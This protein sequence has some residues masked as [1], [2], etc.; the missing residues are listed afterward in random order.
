MVQG[1]PSLPRCLS[2]V[3]DDA[4]SVSGQ[5]Q[6]VRWVSPGCAGALPHGQRASRGWFE[7]CQQVEN[8]KTV[9]EV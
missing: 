6:R 1:P 7:L 9:V 2:F 5:E 3:P 8:A 4:L